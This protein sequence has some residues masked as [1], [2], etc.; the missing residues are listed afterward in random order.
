MSILR[1]YLM[2]L[3]L[4]IS[5]SADI[6]YVNSNA[7]A[8]GDG[9]SWETAYNDLQ[10]A[11][12]MT[13]WGRGDQVWIAQGTYLPI[14]FNSQE[15][16][17]RLATFYIKDEVALYGGFIGVET[18][19]SQRNWD[20]YPT[21]LSGEIY[22]NSDYW[23]I[24][25]M[26]IDNNRVHLDGITIT[27][28]NAN[29]TWE[30][31]SNSGAAVWADAINGGVVTAV[32]CKFLNNSATSYGAV[33]SNI[34]YLSPNS[35]EL[36]N[37]TW[38]ATNCI[39]SGN[40]SYSGGVAKSGTWTVTDCI[41]SDNSAEWSGGVASSGTWTAINSIFSN[42]SSGGAGGVAS[43]GTWTVTNCIFSDNSA[44]G[45]GVANY[46]TWT[47]TNSIF[48]SNS[49]Y[50][51]WGGGVARGLKFSATNCTFSGNSGLPGSVV[52]D[53]I[54]KI[55]TSIFHDN[56][57]NSMFSDSTVTAADST[58]PSPFTV[59]AY[60]VIEGGSSAIAGGTN[61]IPEEFILDVDPLFVNINDPD[62]PD[63]IWMTEDDGLRL[64]QSS[65][66]IGYGDAHFLPSDIYDLDGDDDKAE[67][68]PTDIAGYFRIQDG[69]LD[70]GAYEFGD[71]NGLISFFTVSVSTEVGGTV[72]QD[73]STV[74][75]QPVNL[76]L[77]ATPLEGY[78]F[79]RWIG[80]IEASVE[81]DNPLTLTAINDFS[82]TASFTPDLSDL[83]FDGLTLYEERVTYKTN[84]NTDDTSGDGLKDGVV[85][86]AGFDPTVDYS[87]LVNASRQGM[88]DL[89]A[90]STIMEVL[91]NEATI[92]LKMEESSD[93]ESGSWTEVEGTATMT[94]PVP[95]GSD[96]KFYRFK[97]DI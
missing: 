1:I 73:G 74:Y 88:T 16:D 82:I 55:Y 89:R 70:L 10:D 66:A 46:S 49:A 81:N 86:S 65:P 91:D 96:T 57:D 56:S 39:F 28:G 72:N 35:S 37:T 40:S 90:G 18:D 26:T 84:P 62:G 23:S 17:S 36:Y 24:H 13:V 69:T 67:L 80:N 5:A 9:S 85:V 32:N 31:A 68:L 27:K 60:N 8:G 25:V 2:T 78:V 29:G 50:G 63:D 83:D 4:G 38:T 59:H 51:D 12:A 20:A 52:K 61:N 33:F 22:Q 64:Q 6:F 19:I 48:S 97:L 3:M 93:I 71:Q 77:L 58:T 47:A 15:Q 7:T 75:Y 92:Q 95:T 43:S 54:C 34:R 45:G 30:N 44:R 87:N 41:F 11:L 79:S 53:A 21:I 94:V 14:E 76:S 42:N